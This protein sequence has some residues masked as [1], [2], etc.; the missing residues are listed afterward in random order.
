MQT[1]LSILIC[2]LVADC[3]AL[4]AL[5]FCQGLTEAQR[6]KVKQDIWS[7]LNNSGWD[8][9]NK[10]WARWIL[11]MLL[12]IDHIQYRAWSLTDESGNMLCD[13]GETPPLGVLVDLVNLDLPS[14]RG[15]GN[16][17]HRD[18]MW[19]SDLKTDFKVKDDF[20][21][22][23]SNNKACTGCH[24]KDGRMRGVALLSLWCR[25]LLSQILQSG[26]PPTPTEGSAVNSGI[27]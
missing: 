11:T 23:K 4:E 21:V 24:R 6:C 25:Q 19:Q 27:P 14:I 20:M 17:L 16:L 2:L 10:A 18:E 7:S 8:L 15:A 3:G 22:L 1:T 9:F 13:K 26:R 12:F 5:N